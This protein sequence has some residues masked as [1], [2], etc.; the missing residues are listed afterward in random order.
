MM[1][2]EDIKKIFKVFEKYKLKIKVKH[3]DSYDFAERD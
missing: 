3:G 1:K 2:K